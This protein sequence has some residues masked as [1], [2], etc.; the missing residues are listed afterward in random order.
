[1]PGHDTHLN[2]LAAQNRSDL[3]SVPKPVH[4]QQPS[5]HQPM[6][7]Q[8]VSQNQD[9]EQNTPD[10]PEL[11]LRGGRNGEMCPGRFC[12]IIPCPIPCNFCVFP[13]PC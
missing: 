7:L 12:F 8:Q 1:M 4:A 6:E 2:G 13:C 11:K 3:P 9:Q 5:P 10:E